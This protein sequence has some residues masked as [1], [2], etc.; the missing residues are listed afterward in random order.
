MTLISSRYTIIQESEKFAGKL[1]DSNK[2]RNIHGFGIR[3]SR[4]ISIAFLVVLLLASFQTGSALD[5][6][7]SATGLFQNVNGGT[8]DPTCYAIG[9]SYGGVSGTYVSY[10]WPSV[11]PYDC[12]SC[13]GGIGLATKSG[14]GYVPAAIGTISDGTLFKLGAFTHYNH[15]IC[16]ESAFD[17]VDLKVALTVTGATPP[18]TYFTYTM[19]LHETSNSGVCGSTCEGGYTP[20]LASCPDKVYW[21]NLGSTAKFKGSDGK[22]YTLEIMGFAACSN[23]ATPLAQFV[24]QE[25]A[26]NVACIYAKITECVVTITGNPSPQVI[27]PPNLNTASFSVTATGPAL[28]YQWYK[29]AGATDIKLTNTAPYSGVTTST[30][31]ISPG[32]S[33]QAG[34]Y[35][36]VVT[37]SCG[38]FK[39][40][41][42][43]TL[44]VVNAPEITMDALIT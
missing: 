13:P 37:G 40:S 15:P 44:T 1:N 34:D 39:T 18:T 14:F 30:L 26:N 35:Y 38:T 2:S 17:K 19:N 43:A 31:T 32:T 36:V 11:S 23:P 20:C 22:N 3:W 24:T 25:N 42:A 6:A 12:E 21:G 8:G 33:A 5:L 7:A 4:M 27:C 28:T 29:E 16:F 41:S 9:T 10:G